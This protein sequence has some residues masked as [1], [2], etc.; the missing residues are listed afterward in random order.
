MSLFFL[1]TASTLDAHIVL[2]AKTLVNIVHDL[3]KIKKNVIGCEEVWAFY[4]LIFF[5][6][7]R[8]TFP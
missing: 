4:G 7:A 2:A 5:V 3:L 1:Q 8:V 6:G